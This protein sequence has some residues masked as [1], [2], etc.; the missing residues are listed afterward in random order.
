MRDGVDSGGKSDGGAAIRLHWHQRLLLTLLAGLMG[1]W[2]RTLRFR[3]G[4]EVQAVMDGSLP[5]GIAI[6]WHNRLFVAPEFY[7]RYFRHRRLAALVSASRDGAWLAG[8]MERMGIRPV[9]GSR[10]KRGAQAVREL[11]EANREGYDV[12]ITPDGS[13]GPIYDMKPGAVAVALK[14]GAP[15]VLL[16]FN[17]SRAWRLGSWDRFYL[18]V[19]FSRIEVLIKAYADMQAIGASD[20]A[21]A[22]ARLK[23]ELDA[24]TVDR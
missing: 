21:G 16:S 7:R 20:T 17:F 22:V 4:P 12:G 6:L 2:C 14:T 23:A 11:L 8:L 13:R 15:I 19:P 9:R 18:P 24:I 5:P 3:W 10:H 1:A